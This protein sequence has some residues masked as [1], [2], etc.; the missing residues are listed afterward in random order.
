MRTSPPHSPLPVAADPRELAGPRDA[1][2]L[3]RLA[4]EIDEARDAV[5]ALADEDFDEAVLD[6][7]R[8]AVLARLAAGREGRV[9]AFPAREGQPPRRERPAMKWLAAAAAA[10]LFVG[11]AAGPSFN[12]VVRAPLFGL[13]HEASPRRSAAPWTPVAADASLDVTEGHDELFLLEMESTLNNRG[14]AELRALDDLTPRP[15]TIAVRV[16]P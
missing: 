7:Q 16:R 3:V 6:R 14:V 2:V 9:L 15:T 11:V 8:A 13:A 10:G 12:S 5:E 1:D 4:G